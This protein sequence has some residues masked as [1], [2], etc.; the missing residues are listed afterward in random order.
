MILLNKLTTH[1]KQKEILL[2]RIEKY[3][4]K[5]N[6]ILPTKYASKN[7]DNRVY[8]DYHFNN[9]EKLFKD[10]FFEHKELVELLANI[11]TTMH[12][13]MFGNFS[14]NRDDAWFQQYS[15]NSEHTWHNHSRTQ[16]TNIYFLELPD[17]KYKTEICGLNGK[18]IEYEAEEGEILT[19]PAF[20]LHRSK[21]NGSKRKTILSFNTNYQSA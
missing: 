3:K 19:M 6:C 5:K 12:M 17:T 13:N 4:L 7:N 9:T 15:E 20:L 2:D 8:S 1:E 18:L 21:P 10:D 14:V 16:F 11:G